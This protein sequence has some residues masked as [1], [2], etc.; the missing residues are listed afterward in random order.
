MESQVYM[1]MD[2]Y[3]N[4]QLIQQNSDEQMQQQQQF[5]SQGINIM[6]GDAS[7]QEVIVQDDSNIVYSPM[8]TNDQPQYMIQQQPQEQ[9]MIQQQSP[10]QP[11]QVFFANVS[12]QN[13]NRI[14][15]QQTI[16]LNH[17]IIT[18]QN[19]NQTKVSAI[20]KLENSALMFYF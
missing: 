19:Q 2:P 10:Q 11:Q 15:Q 7:T 17:N 13:Q 14:H 12:P 20:R 18:Q 5:Q 9:Y 4:L 6:S 3:H 8:K 16:A 1:N